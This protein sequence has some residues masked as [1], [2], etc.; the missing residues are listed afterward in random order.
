M[1]FKRTHAHGSIPVTQMHYARKGVVTEEMRFV[2][3]K[4]NV[5][6]DHIRAEVARGR[7][8]IPSNV[9]HE[10]LEPMGIGLALS[11]KI[12]ANIGNSAVSSDVDEELRK[13]DTAVKLGADT[14]MDLSTGGR[15]DAIREAILAHSPVPIGTVPIYQVVA[16]L[17]SIED[18]RAED[19][20][21]MVEHQ[22]KQGVDY[23]TL[24]AGVLLRHLPLARKRITGIVSRGGSLLAA[25]MMAHR[26]ENPLYVH[27]DEILEI[28]RR[29][30]VTISAGDG[31]RPGCLADA[32]DAAQFAELET[33]GELTRRAWDKDVQVMIEGPGHVPMDQIAMNVEM[34]QRICHEA[35]FYV[36][37]PL[38]TDI[39]PGY[40][41]ITSAIGAALAGQ[42]GA[43]LLCYVTPKEHLG[44]PNEGDVR[45]GVIAYKIAAHAADVARGRPGARDRDDELSRARF[46][47][48][49]EKQFQ[50]SLDPETARAMH[51]ESLPADY[52]KSAE[53]C[54]MCGPK[55]CSMQSKYRLDD[56][57]AVI[58]EIDQ[59]ISPT[60]DP[61]RS[62]GTVS[63]PAPR[64]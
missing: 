56:V 21:G 50:L 23:M 62:G 8:V 41:H 17:E 20:V 38:V 3:E 43:S 44:L 57:E 30:D 19:L 55:F 26:R 7:L 14:V 25:W 18:M 22:A 33:L 16:E 54:S 60:A 31:L 28:C 39:A 61:P 24:H 12:N 6:P 15:I 35:P 36:L 34:Q 49:W 48:D 32:S 51:D 40:D 27:W 2:S 10:S 45:Q 46:N 13:L 53:F 5:D 9:H 59:T 42:A 47:F 58:A 64:H 63:P 37:G 29:Y 1:K 52:F 11:C 4:E